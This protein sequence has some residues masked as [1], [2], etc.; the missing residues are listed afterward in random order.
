MNM[1]HLS[2]QPNRRRIFSAK[3]QVRSPLPGLHFIP[4][5]S[6][7]SQI[8]VLSDNTVYMSRVLPNVTSSVRAVK[9]RI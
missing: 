5:A 2:T 3:V 8:G 6:L 4:N 9:A 1:L 7:M